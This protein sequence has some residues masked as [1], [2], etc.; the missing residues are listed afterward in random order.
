MS[1][2]GRARTA[3]IGCAVISSRTDEELEEFWCNE[4]P[5]QSITV[6]GRSRP[7]KPSPREPVWYESDAPPSTN[8][9]EGNA[10][11]SGASAQ[12]RRIA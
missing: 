8:P 6:P 2:S 12:R 4:Q 5:P 9:P 3:E 10:K 11:L 7:E 1:N